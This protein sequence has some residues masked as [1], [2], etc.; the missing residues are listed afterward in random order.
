[1]STDAQSPTMA[2]ATDMWRGLESETVTRLI[3]K[4]CSDAFNPMVTGCR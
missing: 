1:M 3:Q 4:T 2:F